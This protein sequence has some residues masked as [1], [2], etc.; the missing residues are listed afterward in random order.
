MATTGKNNP[1]GGR[2]GVSPQSMSRWAER[3]RR[4]GINFQTLNGDWL[5]MAIATI[6]DAGGA[7]QFGE[8]QGGVGVM[9]KVFVG[10]ARSQLPSI[11]NVELE[12]L[13]LDVVEDWSSTAEDPFLAWG[14]ANP[15]QQAAD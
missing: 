4:P 2:G 13:L 8:L 3:K 1:R 7:I 6:V 11:L 5:K 9:V 15:R 10:D 14:M 12:E